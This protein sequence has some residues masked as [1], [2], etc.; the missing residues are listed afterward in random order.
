MKDFRIVR[1]CRIVQQL[2]GWSRVYIVVLWRGRL[3]KKWVN[4]VRKSI[5]IYQKRMPKARFGNIRNGS[6]LF[7]VM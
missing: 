4:A 2:I 3:W 1:L 5:R 6:I 7:L